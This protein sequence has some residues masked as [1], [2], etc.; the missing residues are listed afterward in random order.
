MILGRVDLT[1]NASIPPNHPWRLFE[2]D[3]INAFAAIVNDA[4]YSSLVRTSR[5]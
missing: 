3:R 4:G 5:P 2:Q 1:P